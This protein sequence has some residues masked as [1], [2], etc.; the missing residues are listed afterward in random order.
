[1]KTTAAD[2]WNQPL[3]APWKQVPL[4]RDARGVE[5]EQGAISRNPLKVRERLERAVDH[6]VD[7]A[8]EIP[9]LSS[10]AAPLPRP[11]VRYDLKGGIAG[12]A[13]TMVRPRALPEQWIRIHP[14]LLARYPV[15]MIQQT[16]PHEIAHLV[17]DWY[18]PKVRDPHGPE[19]MGVMIWFGRPPLAY[20]DMEAAPSARGRV[21]ASGSA[22]L[23]EAPHG[24]R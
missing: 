10:L 2:F 9:H 5:W 13:A 4:L 24:R 1:M 8:R 14:D 6:W 3:S 17:I 7:R 20:H 19:W 21:K 22:L 23:F 15:R 18:L 12:M 16:I 11:K